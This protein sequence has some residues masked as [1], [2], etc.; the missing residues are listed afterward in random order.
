MKNEWQTE[1]HEGQN[2]YECYIQD[3]DGTDVI[4]VNACLSFGRFT[5]SVNTHTV[6]IVA[7]LEINSITRNSLIDIQCD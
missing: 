7:P 4:H 1:I 2:W 6:L 3:S 5:L